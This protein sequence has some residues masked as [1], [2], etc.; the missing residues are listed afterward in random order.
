MKNTPPKV[1]RIGEVIPNQGFLRNADLI[2]KRVIQASVDDWAVDQEPTL[3]QLQ[4]SAS[5]VLGCGEQ[6]Q[7]VNVAGLG[8]DQIQNLFE[9]RGQPGDVF[10]SGLSRLN[11][12]ESSS[13]HG[14]LQ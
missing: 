14:F 5:G 10:G 2:S 13:G 3:L 6:S 7:L 12:A 8:F 1:G 4:D 11:W 9:R